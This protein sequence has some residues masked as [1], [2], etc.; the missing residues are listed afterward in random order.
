MLVIFALQQFET[1]PRRHGKATI[2]ET[3]IAIGTLK[4][5]GAMYGPIMPV[6]KTSQE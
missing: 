2:K 6:I 5:I 1:R 4:A 3:I